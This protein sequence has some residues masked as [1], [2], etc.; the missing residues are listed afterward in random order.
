MSDLPTQGQLLL[1]L[2]QTLEEA[3][4][5]AKPKEIYEALAEKVR[6]PKW[7]RELRAL[8]GTAGEINVWE[9]RVRN[10]RQEATN[11]GFIENNPTKRTKNLWELTDRGKKGLYNCKP[12]ILI[13][14]FTTD[15][16]TAIFA[17][18]ETAVTF[19]ADQSLDLIL[20]SPPYPLVT[21]KSYG[22]KS[23]EQ[24]VEWLTS[25]AAAWKDK[26]APSG[27]LVINLADAFLPGLPALSLY[28]ERLLIN[29][30][31]NLGYTLAQKFFW[32]NPSKLPAPAEW[33]CIR[34][35]RCTPSVEQIY[36]LT[37]DPK[38]AT[39]N[40]QNVLRPYSD[41]MR[42]RMTEG[43]QVSQQ[44]PSGHKIKKGAFAKDNGGSIP[45]NLI[46][47]PHSQ[48]ND[49]YKQACRQADIP[50]H[51][52]RF[53]SILPN[54]FIKF[55]TNPGNLIYDPC[56]GSAVT[57]HVAESL[58]RR[59]IIS[60]RSLTYLKGASFRFTENPALRTYFDK[61]AA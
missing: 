24:Y 42:N 5:K 25:L 23:P 38:A 12:G 60:E 11:H 6:L 26:L 32:E 2:L 49:S 58:G 33:V 3:G 46:V 48:S 9:R 36:W 40:N 7:L 50:I 1:P 53:P 21:Q 4:G 34:R 20:T 52:A 30:V 54:F 44:R 28:Q 51:P 31:D 45:H 43:E 19:I 41:S 27:S 18:A 59:W 15:L 61:V 56:A 10:A 55:L 39:A 16:G 29:L 8:A 14:V 17:E 57:A 22:G 37:K 47:S 13:T 35:L